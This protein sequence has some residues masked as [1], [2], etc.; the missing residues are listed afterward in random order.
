MSDKL[1]KD[2]KRNL[3]SQRLPQAANT[4]FE[5]MIKD[6]NIA[7]EV[8]KIIYPTELVACSLIIQRALQA[9]HVLTGKKG[10][11]GKKC[12]VY[13]QP[14]KRHCLASQLKSN[15]PGIKSVT[16]SVSNGCGF[17]L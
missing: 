17:S 5:I 16:K 9:D 13:Y 4:L 3:N 11:Q 14:V 8:L 10:E 12:V 1:S 15:K 2:N 7:F 6:R